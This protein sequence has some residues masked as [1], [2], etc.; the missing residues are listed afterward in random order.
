MRNS[1]GTG[2]GESGYFYMSYYSSNSAT[3][4]QLTSNTAFNET[5]NPVSA[6]HAY[7]HDP[8]GWIASYGFSGLEGW[9]AGVFTCTAY[10]ENISQVSFYTTDM[11]TTYQAQIYV[12]ANSGPVSGTPA[13]TSAIGTF[14]YPGFHTVAVTPPLALTQ[15]QRFSVVVKLDNPSYAYPIAGQ[16]PE[17]GHSSAA[18]AADSQTYASADGLSWSD[19]NENTDHP[20]TS[21]CVKAFTTDRV[22]AAA[23]TNDLTGVRAYPSPARFS[24]VSQLRFADIPLDAQNVKIRI[25]TLTGQLVRTLEGGRGIGPDPGRPYQVGLWDGRNESGGK[26]ASGVYLYVVTAS[27]KGKKTSKIGILW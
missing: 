27:N 2:W 24:E 11:N 14:K 7:Q 17:P 4:T 9:L 8:L 12:N 22:E 20:H 23:Q 5:Q 18:V 25:Y 10:S 19:L 26:A 6:A 16:Y 15:N 21:A 13:Y 3:D 1:W